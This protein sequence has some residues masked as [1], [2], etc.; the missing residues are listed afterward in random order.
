MAGLFNFEHYY[1]EKS[2]KTDI[3]LDISD[4]SVDD[5][6]PN[7]YVTNNV[8]YKITAIVV[9]GIFLDQTQRIH[10]VTSDDT[11]GE[12]DSYHALG[13]PLDDL[14]EA[15]IFD[16]PESADPIQ[17]F[18]LSVGDQFDEKTITR[19][20]LLGPNET[21][22]MAIMTVTMAVTPR[23]RW[24]N[25]DMTFSPLPNADI[26]QQFW[27]MCTYPSS[28]Y[29]MAV[30]GLLGDVYKGKK[31]YNRQPVKNPKIVFG[32]DNLVRKLNN[33][34]KTAKDNNLGIKVTYFDTTY[35]H[36]VD[37]PESLSTRAERRAYAAALRAA[38]WTAT[39]IKTSAK[40]TAVYP[41]ELVKFINKCN[42]EEDNPLETYYNDTATAVIPN[43]ADAF[44]KLY[45]SKEDLAQ[46]FSDKYMETYKS[47]MSISG[48]R[49]FMS[50]SMRRKLSAN[51][52]RLKKT[53]TRVNRTFALDLASCV[54]YL[55]AMYRYDTPGISFG[56]FANPNRPNDVNKYGI[57]MLGNVGFESIYMTSTI[58]Y[59][60]YGNPLADGAVVTPC[61]WVSYKDMAATPSTDKE[62][63]GGRMHAY[64]NNAAYVDW[65][66]S[67]TRM[68]IA[69]VKRQLADYYAIMY[70]QYFGLNSGDPGYI[71]SCEYDTE[72]KR[73]IANIY[74][75]VGD[76]IEC[77]VNDAT[78]RSLPNEIPSPSDLAPMTSRKEIRYM[79]SVA[80]YADS[81][82]AVI[83]M[84]LKRAGMGAIGR[85]TPDTVP[86]KGIVI[87]MV[88]EPDDTMI[89]VIEWDSASVPSKV[90]NEYDFE[91]NFETLEDI[92]QAT[93]YT[94]QDCADFID[95]MDDAVDTIDNILSVQGRFLGP[96]YLIAQK[97]RLSD[98]KENLEEL[99]ALLNRILWYQ[100]FTNESVFDNKTFILDGNLCT[101]R[102]NVCPY[103]Y[104]PARFMIPVKMYRRVRVK[105]K[106]WGRTRH[107]TVKRSIGVRWAEILFV[108]ND[109][110]ESYPQVTKEP[111]QF[112]LI[113][114]EAVVK[115]NSN[116]P[117]TF[118]FASPIEGTAGIPA[119]AITKFD[120]GT[121][122]LV[123]SSG[124]EIG[125]TF[126]DATTFTSV[127]SVSDVGN[128]V[129]VYGI[130]VPL[131][132]TAPSGDR[133]KVRIEYN[134]P[135]IP[136]NSELKHWAFVN[137]G[138]FD[139]D[140]Y[141]NEDRNTPASDDKKPGWV[142]FNKSSKRIG[143]L[144]AELGI[145]DAVSSLVGI[146]RN[147]FG[148][149]C[150][151]LAETMRSKEDQELMCA[152]GGESTFLSWH[153]YGLAVKILINDQKTGL[154]IE[155][156]SPDMLK[157]ADVADAFAKVCAAG[158]FGK[159]LNLVWC[160][161][162]KIGA[163]NFVWE[164]LPI[165]VNHKDALKFREAILNQE[166][167]VASV[168]Y[169]NVDAMNYVYNTKPSTKVPYI[170]SKSEAYQNA[171]VVNGQ[172]YVSPSSIRNYRVPHD[173]VLRNVLEFCKLVRTKMEANGTQLNDRASMYEWKSL[174]EKSYKQLLLYYGLIG[175]MSA[176]S[177]LVCGDYVERYQSVIDRKYSENVVEMV[178]EYL[179]DLYKDAKIF[180]E[181]SAD[182]GAWLS[183]ADGRLHL[184]STN[185]KSIFSEQSKDNFYGEKV[186]ALENTVR[187]LY[188]EGVFR[189]E[190]ELAAMG[191]ELEYVSKE[192]YINGY[193][194]DGNV[195][196]GDALLLHSLIA[197]QIREEFDKLRDRFEN[198][199]GALMYDHF[200]DG[201]NVS[202]TDMLENEFGLIA[203]QDLIDI[204]NLKAIFTNKAIS[205]DIVNNGVE[206]SGTGD[207]EV[208]EKVV[209]NAEMAGVRKAS[210]TK[211]HINVT[212][213]PSSM[214]T[215]Q[216]Y[217]V[218]M[219]GSMTQANDMFSK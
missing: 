51:K 126:S 121:L 63:Y 186:A 143:D 1:T 187:G 211:E 31:W 99:H 124:R 17:P 141:A 25:P 135:Y 129:Y 86:D 168:G 206:G 157:L 150:V 118:T 162:L 115:Q 82:I 67:T 76:V 20:E 217:K 137:Y 184:K 112:Y 50:R 138:A 81:C 4:I 96:V 73:F 90:L 106:R 204:D 53:E 75:T 209:S 23:V 97:L 74:N 192:P 164:F 140:K 111:M 196:G 176:A 136:Y 148:K 79:G 201:P 19:M 173:I 147:T 68:S 88:Q 202:M 160:G 213:T 92:G 56:L 54:N 159:P 52:Y 44:K 26:D 133:T 125:V 59:D 191:I 214:T 198:Y 144:R 108:D 83:S 33:L 93:T 91:P 105:Y 8:M 103:L 27:Q 212:V 171:L 205:D 13:Y 197:T 30:N 36:D 89:D 48:V 78:D 71:D 61:A 188:Y 5:S 40:Y 178:K 215:E 37:V 113:G 190:E 207:G 208:F 114:Q 151:E 22:G 49:P 177:T 43:V 109:V 120:H 155:D 200:A 28:Y 32:Y 139:Q 167:P 9:N 3:A 6:G 189:T 142:I 47:I 161:R 42:A 110:Y 165:G 39:S 127:D 41:E 193:D 179:G 183:L 199:G 131:E 174:N 11:V 12:E 58:S 15:G 45:E 194:K 163:N 195:V 132:P 145:Y 95:V 158:T 94:A 60:K 21:I 203:G 14:V 66:I 119:G 2:I 175:S 169:V 123:N 104:M 55:R 98:A 128:P 62:L 57:R 107:K 146:L 218:I 117:A 152:G 46:D 80:H 172:H 182:G 170:L 134:M 10:I 130:Y 18:T 116:G 16:M 149:G 210:L 72:E 101:S 216:L 34:N 166:D 77:K 87:S 65:K 24:M 69:D 38:D 35:A 84:E 122:Q 102:N 7:E 185:I 180:I 153:N 64:T 70:N 100:K 154:P 181:D 85:M 156:G 29:A 219:K